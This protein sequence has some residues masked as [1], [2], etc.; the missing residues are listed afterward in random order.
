[1]DWLTGDG[2]LTQS[3]VSVCTRLKTSTLFDDKLSAL[4]ELESLA[5]EHPLEVGR[6]S[7]PVLCDDV[8]HLYF[9]HDDKTLIK[10]CIDILILLLL[11]P[12]QPY[13]V[14]IIPRDKQTNLA[15]YEYNLDLLFKTNKPSNRIN[16][17]IE[18]LNDKYFEYPDMQY[19]I[20]QILTSIA[21]YPSTLHKLQKE[22]INNRAMEKLSELLKNS[23][24]ELIRNSCI[25]L[26]V[27]LT[28]NDKQIQ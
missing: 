24:Q 16:I 6:K 17:F 14:N 13:D 26:F 18:L 22:L 27:Y 5:S 10:K 19:N 25:L 15:Y 11:P 20:I 4:A 23:Q 7:L 8:L 1:M 3:I 12:E 2:Q 9:D 28:K 21:L